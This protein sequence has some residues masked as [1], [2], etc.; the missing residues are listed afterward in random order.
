MGLVEI[1]WEWHYFTANNI[2][3]YGNLVLILPF[4]IACIFRFMNP[5]INKKLWTDHLSR[6][7]LFLSCAF[8]IY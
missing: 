1:D 6:I 2:W 5:D 8:Y 3:V 4:V 7:F